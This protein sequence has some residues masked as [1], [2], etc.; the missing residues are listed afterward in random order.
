[1]KNTSNEE[2]SGEEFFAL[3]KK[4]SM[5]EYPLH[6]KNSLS[7]KFSAWAKIY[8]AKKAPGG[9]FSTISKKIRRRH[10]LHDMTKKTDGLVGRV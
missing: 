3:P 9:K 4:V 1:V 7:Q 10:P 5:E 8:P 2:L 6:A